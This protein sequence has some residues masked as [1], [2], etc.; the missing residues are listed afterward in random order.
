MEEEDGN[1]SA[2]EFKWNI[3]SK[4]K[5]SKTFSATYPKAKVSIITPDN[6]ETFIC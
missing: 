1:L 5:I 2:Y 6:Y 4:A 3:T